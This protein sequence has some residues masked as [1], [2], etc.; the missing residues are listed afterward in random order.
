MMKCP[1]CQVS[2]ITNRR[3]SLKVNECPQCY[4]VWLKSG[5]I[6][7]MITETQLIEKKTKQ[8]K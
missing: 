8:V 5:D 4:G 1:E 2:F 7:K 3:Q 6:E